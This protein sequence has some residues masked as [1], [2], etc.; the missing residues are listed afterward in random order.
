MAVAAQ[1]SM[2]RARLPVPGPL[3]NPGPLGL[4]RQLLRGLQ[5]RRGELGAPLDYDGKAGAPARSGMSALSA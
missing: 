1:L 5:R 4:L 3:L 2:A